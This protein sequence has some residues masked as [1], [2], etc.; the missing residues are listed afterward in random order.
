M[1]PL[2]VA[3]QPLILVADVS[4]AEIRYLL[5]RAA[6]VKEVLDTLGLTWSAYDARRGIAAP[7]TM[8]SEWSI[9]DEQ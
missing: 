3:G 4:G 9:P 7:R 8:S 1:L 5:E 2:R 6:N